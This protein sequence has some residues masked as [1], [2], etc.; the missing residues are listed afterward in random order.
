MVFMI[1]YKYE[2]VRGYVIIVDPPQVTLRME[3]FIMYIQSQNY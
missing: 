1:L 2:L 3:V